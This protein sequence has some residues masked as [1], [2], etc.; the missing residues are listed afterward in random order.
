ML[1]AL[2]SDAWA[3]ATTAGWLTSA[4]PTA[5]QLTAGKEAGEIALWGSVRS[6]RARQVALWELK[7]FFKADEDMQAQLGLRRQ[8][9]QDDTFGLIAGIAVAGVVASSFIEASSLPP[10]AKVPLGAACSLAPF[11]ALVAGVAVPQELQG[12]VSAFRRRDL[13]Y[14]QRQNYHEARG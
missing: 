6:P 14:R 3:L 5:A 7:L 13:A 9:D 8:R 4:A 11:L 10:P 1:L 2:P 12:A